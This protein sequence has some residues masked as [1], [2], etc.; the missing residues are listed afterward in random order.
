[1]REIELRS[2]FCFLIRAIKYRALTVT[3]NGGG[4]KKIV[5][6]EEMPGFILKDP[7]VLHQTLKKF[8]PGSAPW[9]LVII[10]SERNKSDSMKKLFPPSVLASI[11][12][13]SFNPVANTNL[14]KCLS[15]IAMIE[16]SYGIRS[17]KIPDKAELTA[18][19][20]KGRRKSI[21]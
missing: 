5:L 8:V 12:H 3:P 20:A 19:A 7:E 17:F 18:L 6:I 1:M 13:I 15:S 11:S 2:I 14:V 9:P 16:S 4:A 21:F 10:H